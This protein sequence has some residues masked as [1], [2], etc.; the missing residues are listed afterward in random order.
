M[1][2]PVFC[3]ILLQSPYITA[4]TTDSSISGLQL[5]Q[6]P[7]GVAYTTSKVTLSSSGFHGGWDYVSGGLGGEMPQLVAQCWYEL[8]LYQA[9]NLELRR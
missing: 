1:S 2:V 3:E 5:T 4:I 7:E 9:S 8:Y 6:T